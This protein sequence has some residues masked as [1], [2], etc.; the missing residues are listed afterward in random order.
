MFVIRLDVDMMSTLLVSAV[1]FGNSKRGS[2]LHWNLLAPYMKSWAPM[3]KNGYI[4]PLFHVEKWLFCFSVSPL[5]F[6]FGTSDWLSDVSICMKFLPRFWLVP[7]VV[8]GFSYSLL[9]LCCLLFFAFSAC[10]SD[11]QNL[12]IPTVF[13]VLQ[14]A[15]QL[16]L[17][18][19]KTRA[20]SQN[21]A[22][23][24][25]NSQSLGETRAA[26][27]RPRT[28]FTS[29]GLIFYSCSFKRIVVLNI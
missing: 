21:F 5:L 13:F 9:K 7:A 6:V 25:R 28:K 27:Q 8:C 2:P 14:I 23:S 3:P 15:K 18:A 29:F 22:G 10:L 11:L 20:S 12:S 16:R 19:S 1:F 24:R 26:S 17:W 4:C